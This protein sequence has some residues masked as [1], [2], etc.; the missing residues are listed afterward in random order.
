M[1]DSPQGI[2]EA[3]LRLSEAE[4]ARVIQQLIDSLSPDAE[5]LIDDVWEEELDRRWAEFQSGNGDP[6][7]WSIL[8]NQE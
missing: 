7:P 5:Q 2:V 6:V 1:S 3:A 8:R 4:R